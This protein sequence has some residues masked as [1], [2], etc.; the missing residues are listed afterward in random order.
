MSTKTDILS[1]PEEEFVHP[2]NR[3][4]SGCGLGIIYRIGLKALGKDWQ[5]YDPGSAPQL[6]YCIAGAVSYRFHQTAVRECDIRFH[7]RCGNGR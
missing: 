4:C 3:A 1:L 6:S 2:G 5:G 7:G